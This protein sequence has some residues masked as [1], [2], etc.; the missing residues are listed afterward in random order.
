[1]VRHPAA[2]GPFYTYSRQNFI[3]EKAYHDHLRVTCYVVRVTQ[4]MPRDGNDPLET[5][6]P[7]LQKVRVETLP[8]RPGGRAHVEEGEVGP[9]GNSIMMSSL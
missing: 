4:V 9:G 5:P 8:G 3:H 2:E 7:V 1:M 6:R